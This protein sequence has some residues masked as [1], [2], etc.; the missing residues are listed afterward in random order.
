MMTTR[1]TRKGVNG[2]AALL[3]LLVLF[4]VPAVARGAFCQI[5]ADGTS[6]GSTCSA[7]DECGHT[8]GTPTGRCQS[9]EG[10]VISGLTCVDDAELTEVA[11]EAEAERLRAAVTPTMTVSIPG[12]QLNTIRKYKSSD[13]MHEYVEIPWLADYVI[14]VYRYSVFIGSIIAITMI[15]IGG[16]QYLISRGDSGQIGNAKKR[17]GNALIGLI[18]ILGT[19]LVLNSINPELT[20]LRPLT[21]KQVSPDRYDV[22][23]VLQSTTEDTGNPLEL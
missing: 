19:F 11:A 2:M 9:I 6:C 17:I 5:E 16:V 20:I 14:A 10:A 3:M 8:A 22:K 12:L 4:L 21:L 7:G 23:N 15:M 1:K 18:I 13:G